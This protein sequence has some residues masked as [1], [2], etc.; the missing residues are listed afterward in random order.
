MALNAAEKIFQ[1]GVEQRYPNRRVINGRAA[2]LTQPHNGRGACH[3]CGPCEQGCS[4]GAYFSSQSSTLPAA[5][6]TGNLTLRPDS[7]VHSVIYDSEKDRATGVRIIDTNTKEMRE[8][9]ARI[10]FLNA[11]TLGTTQILLNSTS[12]RFPDGLGNSSGVLGHYLMDHHYQIGATAEYPGVDDRYYQGNRPNGMYVV[13]FRNLGDR[14]SRHPDY[15]RGYGFQGECSRT[16]WGRGVETAEFG[17]D[18]KK[19][20]RNPGP[21]LMWLGAWGEHL[22]S[23]DNYVKLSDKTDAYGLPQMR[24]NC[25]WGE[26]ELAMRR[27]MKVTTAEMLEASGASNI[28]PFD[29]LE[30]G[31]AEPGLCIHE[32]GTARMGLD[33][34]TSFLNAFN[35]SHDVPNVFVTD[36]ACMAST[37][38]QNPSLT[39]MAITARACD[40][41]VAEMKKGNL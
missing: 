3:Y 21:F 31:G 18:F 14:A 20:L 35:Q 4:V 33:R 28:E 26:N 24:I 16:S 40:H 23:Y 11:S 13:R 34:K 17:V 2:V 29:N 12:P 19:Q 38:C 36:G 5:T 41:A 25:A 32:M 1:R 22:P 27:D 6:A 9:Y 7:L 8:V 15:V 39:Y 10:I 30:T 37:A